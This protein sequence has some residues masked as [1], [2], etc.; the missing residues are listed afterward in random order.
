[1]IS[2]IHPIILVGLGGLFGA[3]LRYVITL[4]LKN[5]QLLPIGTLVVNVIGSFALGAVFAL[6]NLQAIDATWIPL[7]GTGFM[8]SFTTMS[9]FAVETLDLS[10]SNS[11]ELALINFLLMMGLVFVGAFLGRGFVTIL[12]PIMIDVT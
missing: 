10:A 9:S 11:L 7:I 6:L 3:I 4:S 1:M 12:Y 8:G 5:Y 2:K